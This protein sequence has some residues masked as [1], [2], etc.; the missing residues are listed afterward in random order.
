MYSKRIL[1][2]RLDLSGSRDIIG[3]A[4]ISF[5][6]G[7]FLLVVLWNQASISN[8]FRGTQWRMLHNGLVVIN[9][10]KRPLNKDQGHLFWYQSISYIRLPIGCQ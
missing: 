1:G 9:Y 4:T 6:M 5:P 8:G 7:H 2:S 3:H 10:L